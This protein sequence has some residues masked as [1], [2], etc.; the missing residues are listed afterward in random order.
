MLPH[1]RQV[2]IGLRN[3]RLACSA[4]AS[5]DKGKD[6]PPRSFIRARELWPSAPEGPARRKTSFHFG[7]DEPLLVQ[8]VD[9]G[10]ILGTKAN[11]LHGHQIRQWSDR[12]PSDLAASAEPRDGLRIR[13]AHLFA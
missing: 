13:G 5:P 4:C 10:F 8:I 2:P 1:E 7:R 9:V 3:C 12:Y 11:Q 6:V